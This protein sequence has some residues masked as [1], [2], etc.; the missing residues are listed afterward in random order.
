VTV[1]VVMFVT[2]EGEEIGKRVLRRAQS[3][4]KSDTK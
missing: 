2:L 1:S 4:I 3:G